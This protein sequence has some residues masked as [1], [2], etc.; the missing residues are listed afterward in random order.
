MSDKTDKGAGKGSSGADR[1]ISGV[2]QGLQSVMAVIGENYDPAVNGAVDKATQVKAQAAADVGSRLTDKLDVARQQGAQ[3]TTQGLESIMAVIGENYEEEPNVDLGSPAVAAPPPVDAYQTIEAPVKN[4]IQAAPQ[5]LSSSEA[6]SAISDLVPLLTDDEQDIAQAHSR[7]LAHSQASSNDVIAI[8][9]P[10]PR[11][12]G[13][14]E[15]TIG[16]LLTQLKTDIS[17]LERGSSSARERFNMPAAID[18]A[19]NEMQSLLAE[20]QGDISALRNENDSLKIQ[21]AAPT[22]SLAA[23]AAT[24][25][26][27]ITSLLNQ[28]Q[29]DIV[30]LRTEN[31]TL[32]SRVG[33]S[34]AGDSELSR[35]LSQLQGD[36]SGLRKENDNYKAL[37][38]NTN[39]GT[40]LGQAFL[41]TVGLL[42][43]VGGATVGGM[44]Y[45]NSLNSQKNENLLAMLGLQEGQ[46][47]KR[48]RQALVEKAVV[49]APVAV[50]KGVVAP[51]VAALAPVRAPTPPPLPKI[52]VKRPKLDSAEVRALLAD[53]QNLIELGDLVSARQMLE[54][55]MSQKSS[56][57]AY[58]LGNTFD[59]LHL[60]TMASVLSVEPNITR[61][62]VLYYSAARQGHQA[63]AKRLAELRRTPRR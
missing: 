1:S 55:A 63:A 40:S 21:Y 46:T 23:A 42:A 52:T 59:P 29:G 37:Y 48:A 62:K 13:R 25:G 44:Y 7:D 17:T 47:A 30:G 26:G 38:D 3:T 28:L 18:S 36:I 8:K 2:A 45:A 15:S 5:D 34:P 6:K 51:K 16:D 14:P 33:G 31:S 11:S 60:A 22:P 35:L 39:R 19:S 49:A 53:A 56:E 10:P 61:A 27:E 57:A 9:P 54:Y 4:L 58:K 24:G 50:P 20:L 32:R 41:M 12:V 43:L